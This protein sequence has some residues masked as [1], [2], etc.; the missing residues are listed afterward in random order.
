MKGCCDEARFQSLEKCRSA[1]MTAC[2]S[3]TAST[4]LPV[5]SSREKGQQPTDTKGARDAGG[6]RLRDLGC[7]SSLE[8]QVPCAFS[9][10]GVRG[11][12]RSAVPVLIRR[13][14][15]RGE[16]QALVFFFQARR[17]VAITHTGRSN[18]IEFTTI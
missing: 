17:G 1:K 7:A 18:L 11:P 10:Q 15:G 9:A 8:H 6:R 16:T 13:G 12:W 2:M 3:L 14:C 4:I 5:S